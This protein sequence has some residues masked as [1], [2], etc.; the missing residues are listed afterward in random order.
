[1]ASNSPKQS[2]RSREEVPP[3]TCPHE[4]LLNYRHINHPFPPAPSSI[5]PSMPIHINPSTHMRTSLP[6][7]PSANHQ[8]RPEKIPSPSMHPTSSPPSAQPSVPDTY[9]P[10]PRNGPRPRGEES[11]LGKIKT[12]TCFALYGDSIGFGAQIKMDG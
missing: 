1:M 5:H 9:R 12:S 6:T 11:S 10:A 4:Y 7:H 2:N 3:F 8:A